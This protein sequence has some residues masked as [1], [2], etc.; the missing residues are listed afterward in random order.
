MASAQLKNSFT[1]IGE[2][3]SSVLPA[4][5]T[6]K[7][8]V[9]EKYL[10]YFVMSN[11]HNKMLFYGQYALHHVTD[12]ADFIQRLQRIYDKDELLHLS[13]GAI[14]LGIDTAYSLLPP[15]LLFMK[16]AQ[17]QAQNC[18]QAGVSLIYTVPEEWR[19]KLS[20]LFPSG[21]WSHTGSS[22]LNQLVGLQSVDSDR[23]FINVATDYFDVVRFRDGGSV[24]LMNRYQYKTETDF[25]YFVLL[26]C[27]ELKIDRNVTELILL[28]E[29]NKQSKIYDICYRY[30]TNI[31][32]IEA[33]EGITFSKEFSEYAP[34]LH[35]NLYTL[36]V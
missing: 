13:F 8:L 36:Q 1:S 17:Q 6:L 23:L 12:T 24:L 29:V 33:P 18:L 25:I 7:L 34:H 4:S 10:R 11:T 19:K 30:F 16:G 3:E 22:L 9:S 32:F 35:F 20:E 21:K 14:I 5:L 2:I 31:E 28:G 27:E 26:C 15:E